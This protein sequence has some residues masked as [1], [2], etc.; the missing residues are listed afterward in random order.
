MP[1]HDPHISPGAARQ[2]RMFQIIYPLMQRLMYSSSKLQFATKKIAGPATI[3]IPTRHGEL[4]TLVY[5]PTA[6]DVR[7]QKTDGR[8]PPV[9]LI[10]HGGAFI[11]RVPEQEDNVSR[12]LASEVGCYVVIPDYDTAPAVRFPVGEEESYDVFRWIH[13]HGREMG[14]D[15]N[16]LSVGGASAGGKLALN[17]ALMAIDD[18]YYRPAAV[19]TEYGVANISMSDDRRTSEKRN[20]VVA[21]GLMTLVR[22]TYFAGCD[23]TSPLASPALHPR[24]AELP[25]TLVLTASYDT[26]RHESNALA[27]DLSAK[28]VAVTHREI[29]GVDHGFTHALP[30]EAAREAIRMMGGH[31]AAAYA[32][33]LRTSETTNNT[34]GVSP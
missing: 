19:S 13:E 21:P 2:A 16:R 18:G 25:P 32:A 23:L 22:S 14:W 29:P 17:V 20:P 12:Y 11:I 8:L 10:T 28:G 7:R 33:A 6:E 34:R 26:L 24:L 5:A 30:V 15:G 27:R 3:R 9:H 4:R 31:L 1:R